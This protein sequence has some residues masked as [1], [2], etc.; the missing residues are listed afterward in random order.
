MGETISNDHQ[1]GL[2][3]TK[4]GRQPTT[5]RIEF[6]QFDISSLN[7]P[8]VFVSFARTG[9]YPSNDGNER[10]PTAQIGLEI[11]DINPP[12]T[13][14]YILRD[15]AGITES[16]FAEIL[17]PQWYLNHTW[18]YFSRGVRVSS[19]WSNYEIEYDKTL[20]FRAALYDEDNNFLTLSDEL[21]IPALVDRKVSNFSEQFNLVYPN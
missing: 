9:T 12:S 16:D 18:T 21:E 15:T 2:F 10:A 20:Y 7:G 5:N 11:I 19:F 1:L 17:N 8:E 3:V 6:S 4:D 13:M 14:K